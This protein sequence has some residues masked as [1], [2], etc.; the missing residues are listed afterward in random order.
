MWGLALKY[1]SL[2]KVTP[3][4]ATTKYG[5]L[6]FK[7][8]HQ[9][10]IHENIKKEPHQILP[11]FKNSV[12]LQF[13]STCSQNFSDTNVIEEMLISCKRCWLLNKQDHT[14]NKLCHSFIF[15]V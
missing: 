4:D 12:L 10:K 5:V 11:V 7:I 13:N 1:H 6:S 15:K 9:C 8:I 2:A 14:V 3:I